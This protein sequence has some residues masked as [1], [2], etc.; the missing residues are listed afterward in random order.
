MIYKGCERKIIMIK[1]TGS[2]YFDEAYFI[3]KEKQET[4]PGCNECDMIA[5]A[6]RLVSINSDSFG[7][8]KKKTAKNPDIFS[9]LSGVLSGAAAV[10]IITLFVFI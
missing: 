10:G 7:R 1:N 9:F 2:E 5:E 6:N 3:V 8:R 4:Q